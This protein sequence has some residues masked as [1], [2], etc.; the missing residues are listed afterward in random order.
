M[1]SSKLV[2]SL[3]DFQDF[4]IRESGYGTSVVQNNEIIN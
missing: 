4:E 2:H 3:D 1:K